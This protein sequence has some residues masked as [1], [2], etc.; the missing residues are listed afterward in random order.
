MGG[1]I[2]VAMAGLHWLQWVSYTKE[3][4]FSR[5]LPKNRDR[6]H[7][8]SA[9]KPDCLNGSCTAAPQCII[10]STRHNSLW[11]VLTSVKK[12]FHHDYHRA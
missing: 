4:P 11:E 10:S 9:Y 3:Q 1:R 8:K 2:Y 12:S 5:R 6:T 7:M